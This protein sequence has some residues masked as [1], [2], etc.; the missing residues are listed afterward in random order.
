M[1]KKIASI[2]SEI[3]FFMVAAWFFISSFGIVAGGSEYESPA[4][5]PRLLGGIMMLLCL[6][7]LYRDIF[8]DLKNIKT[9]IPITGKKNLLAVFL[10]I[11]ALIVLWSL[12]GLVY[13]WL[14]LVLAVLLFLLN[15]D[16][17]SKKKILKSVIIA[18]TFSLAV[19]LV[20]DVL[21]SINL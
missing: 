19:F 2:V 11:V 13:I 10:G 6:I 12:F 3:L 15:E 18:A 21:F 1:S 14:F 20:F 9:V 7:S 4:Y 5:Y 16:V 17:F 8:G